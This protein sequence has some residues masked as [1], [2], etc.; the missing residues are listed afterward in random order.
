MI[1][2]KAVGDAA[3]NYVGTRFRIRGR[4]RMGIDCVGLLLA[5]GRDAGVSLQDTDKQYI[6]TP[7]VELFKQM[8]RA[9]S[10]PGD[11]NCIQTGSILMLRQGITPCHCGL[12]IMEGGA[13]SIVHASMEYRKV[14]LEPL[15]KFYD[16]VIDV[17]EYHGVI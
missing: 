10:R 16:Q 2:R 12:A 4:S 8:I 6:R 1:L 7:D 9:Q 14:L 15:S 17:R 3:L 13:A 5:A 11:I